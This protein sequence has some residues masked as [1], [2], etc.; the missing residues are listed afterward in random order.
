VL[1][2]NFFFFFLSNN[3]KTMMIK[4]IEKEVEKIKKEKTGS[5]EALFEVHRK[6]LEKAYLARSRI[7]KAL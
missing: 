3:S 7:M 6:D 5:K 4:D 2:F 1:F